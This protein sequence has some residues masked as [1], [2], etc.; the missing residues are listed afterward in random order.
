[1]NVMAYLFGLR[2]QSLSP[3]R[4]EIGATIPL[5][6]PLALTELAYISIMTTDV[7]MMGW[8]G[9]DMLAA[10]SLAMRLNFFFVMIPFGVLGA[11]APIIAQHLGARRFRMVRRAVRQGLWLAVITSLPCLIVSWNAEAILVLLGQ[12]PVL[13][14]AGQSYLRYMIIGLIP[15]MW[16]Y[17]LAEFL[18]AHARPRPALVVTVLAIGLNALANYVLMFGAFGFPA[19]G[20]DG[21]G[22]STAVV[23]IFMFAALLFYVLQDRRLRRY[24]ILG[25]L[26]RADIEQMIEMVRVG[27]P[28]ALTNM[29][30]DGM[31]LVM[32]LLMGLLGTAALAAHTVAGQSCAI[33]FM[34]SGGLTLAATVRVGR[35]TGAGHHVDARRAG[36]TAIGLATCF[37]IV[38]AMLFWFHGDLVIGIFLDPSL[39][40]NAEAVAL[41]ISLLAIAAVFQLADGMQ[42]TAMGAL[43]GLKDTRGPM[44]VTLIVYWGLAVPVSLLL[45]LVFEQRSEAIWTCLAA[46]FCLVAALLVR[47]FH[48]QTRQA[49]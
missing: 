43:R 21:A 39:P 8:L 14:K 41:A 42:V 47:R 25:R 36:W 46:A 3:W 15:A 45:V 35:A 28:I 1:M 16:M 12:D 33:F 5:A 10:G 20:L 40:E 44:L 9:S 30:E 27:F 7:I 26:W 13:A 6:I 18:A 24:R 2:A 38:P 17:V 11:V 22:I 32:T 23:D 29:S 31:Y 37:A 34:V 48:K 19:L 4:R 49:R